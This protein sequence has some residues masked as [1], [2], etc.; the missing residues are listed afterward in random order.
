MK[1]SVFYSWQSD[2]NEVREMIYDALHEACEKLLQEG[3][4]YKICQDD[5]VIRGS[6]HISVA[7]LSDIDSADVFL[8][9]LSPVCEYNGKDGKKI[10]PNSNVMFEFG[11]AMRALGEN[12]C[13]QLVCLK[14]G[15]TINQLPFDIQQ[16]KAVEITSN[17]RTTLKKLLENWLRAKALKPLREGVI[18]FNNNESALTLH[19]EFIRISYIAPPSKPSFFNKFKTASS[20]KNE[21]L[22]NSSKQFIKNFSMDNLKKEVIDPLAS[23]VTNPIGVKKNCLPITL[24]LENIGKEALDEVDIDITLPNDSE[25]VFKDTNKSIP[26]NI[27]SDSSKTELPIFA[28][29]KVIKNNIKT[30]N[31]G[32]KKPIIECYIS[33][34]PIK[35][36]IVLT[37]EIIS[38]TFRKSGTLTIHCDPIYI[39]KEVENTEKAGQ[40]EVSEVIE[41]NSANES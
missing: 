25:A 14:Q 10:M 37:W 11:Y 4:E 17:D 7:V 21:E 36:D 13:K 16:R 33:L 41:K 24:I 5:D 29:G 2:R 1:Y 9:D 12:N 27:F 30:I 8:G 34:P 19:P 15:Q 6:E 35:T 26:L 22:K 23:T 20:D 39:N 38:R 40:T 28:N 18:I 3:I 32:A 31:P